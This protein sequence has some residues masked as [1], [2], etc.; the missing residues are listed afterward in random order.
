MPDTPTSDSP[1]TPESPGESFRTVRP[2]SVPVSVVSRR[3][4]RTEQVFSRSLEEGNTPVTTIH[5]GSS[6]S[7]L[8]ASNLLERIQ[9]ENFERNQTENPLSSKHSQPLE[10]EMT[11]C[12]GCHGPM[13]NGQHN[14]SAP[15]KNHC[16]F[17]HSALCRGGFPE[18]ESWRPCPDGYVYM[19]TVPTSG[20]ESTMDT[21]DFRPQNHQQL[22]HASSTPGMI[23]GP[24]PPLYDHSHA[25]F[26][27]PHG[28]LQ[29]L[30]LDQQLDVHDQDRLRRQALGEG[31]RER[32]PRI[33]SLQY[34]NSSSAPLLLPG[35]GLAAD[36]V[37]IQIDEHRATN[38]AQ[39]DHLDRPQTS[40]NITQLRAN[41]DL[42][43]SVENQVAN[44]RNR[45]PSLSAAKTA[46]VSPANK[47][48]IYH[49]GDGIRVTAGPAH[50]Q[51]FVPDHAASAA[52]AP[53]PPPATAPA[54]FPA[55]PVA[56]THLV[57]TTAAPV[58]PR[59]PTPVYAP[60]PPTI[61]VPM[62]AHP[63][64]M[65]APGA[66]HYGQPQFGGA[67][68]APQQQQQFGPNIPLQATMTAAQT[69]SQQAQSVIA[70]SFTHGIA[71]PNHYQP[72]TPYYP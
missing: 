24:L 65:P 20:F 36:A 40:P 72:S 25:Q 28:Q 27:T 68:P 35:Q 22:G 17:S 60:A 26:V 29:G 31:A 42:R 48:V 55:P 63:P 47:S 41:P 61:S 11:V 54:V 49:G 2:G 37:Q 21:F 45:I 12:H 34:A 38:Q 5:P 7:S 14:G 69:V 39:D 59:V 56:P 23:V 16:L 6:R 46:S 70:P 33:V 10:D 50:Q 15:G 19:A 3:I 18:T 58:L 64:R 66:I 9:V 67:V 13:G 62:P 52:A 71:A 1:G 57:V 51:D 44:F 30:G 43:A 4:S 32:T 8:R 53:A